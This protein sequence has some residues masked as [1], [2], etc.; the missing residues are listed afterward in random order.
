MGELVAD[1]LP[2]SA[3][4]WRQLYDGARLPPALPD[5][6]PV[7]LAASV[8]LHRRFRERCVQQ[9]YIAQG[10]HQ[11]APTRFDAPHCR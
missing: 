7:Y 11:R 1:D 4:L 6:K 8:P 3:R 9:R 5:V 10:M 2:M